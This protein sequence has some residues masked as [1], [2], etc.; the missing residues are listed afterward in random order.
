MPHHRFCVI[1]LRVDSV[2]VSTTPEFRR[3]LFWYYY[4]KACDVSNRIPKS[5]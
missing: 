3:C 2:V 5:W 4:C 1:I